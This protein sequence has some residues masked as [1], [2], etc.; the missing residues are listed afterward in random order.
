MAMTGVAVTATAD[1]AAAAQP[2][3]AAVVGASF[4]S[5]GAGM[6]VLTAIGT[7]TVAGLY[8]ATKGDGSA[9]K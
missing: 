3:A 8:Y 5:S 6:L 9:S 4:F 1:V 2:G 7:G